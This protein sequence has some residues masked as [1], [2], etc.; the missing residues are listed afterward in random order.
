MA[1]LFHLSNAGVLFALF[2]MT[3]QAAQT[4][5]EVYKDDYILVR[6]GIAEIGIQPIHIGDALSMVVQLEFDTRQVR[7]ETLD[8]DF[9]QRAFSR[10]KG[11]KLYAAPDITE[12]E[13]K[14][15]QL[16][17]RASWPFQILDCPGDLETCAGFKT[18]D[19]PLITVS[20]Q[21]IDDS[22]QAL[23][24]KSVRFRP[25]PDKISLSP[26]IAAVSAP[27]GKITDHFPSG[28]Y[29]NTLPIAGSSHVG[30]AALLVG[31]LLFAVGVNRRF[32]KGGPRQHAA[33]RRSTTSRWEHALEHLREASV[34]DDQWADLLR[35]AATWYCMD[36]LGRNP[37]ANLANNAASTASSSHVTSNFQLFFVDVL[38]QNAIASQD[39]DEY[40]TRFMRIAKV[41]AGS[42]AL[43]NMA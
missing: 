42:A 28:A 16:K 9:F 12:E 11:F 13:A 36:E 40:L 17:I 3:A 7:V 32:S 25:S 8:S 5:P 23:N 20:Y 26:A 30:L 35:R 37:Y 15:S 39:R 1:T 29:P 33:S 38:Q 41:T 18:Y 21:L 14:D 10:Q 24:N 22:G 31:S 6:A 19:L 2:A 34:P 27:V 43:E 4:V